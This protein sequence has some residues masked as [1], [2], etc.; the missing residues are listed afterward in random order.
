MCRI[1]MKHPTHNTAMCKT[2]NKIAILKRVEKI[3]GCD[4]T[5]FSLISIFLHW[6][7]VI[8]IWYIKKSSLFSIKLNYQ[9]SKLKGPFFSR[10]IRLKQ[11]EM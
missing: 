3:G 7:L 11:K 10:Y 4:A 6:E 2:G 8:D 9:P 5:N 1:T